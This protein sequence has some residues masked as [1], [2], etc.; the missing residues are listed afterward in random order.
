MSAW[1]WYLETAF[2]REWNSS[3]HVVI[4]CVLNVPSIQ[5]HARTHSVL[6]ASPLPRF[7]TQFH[8]APGIVTVPNDKWH[9][10]NEW[11]NEWAC[12]HVI[13]FEKKTIDQCKEWEEEGMERKYGKNPR[14]GTRTQTKDTHE[15]QWNGNDSEC[16]T[17]LYVFSWVV[18]Y[19]SC[20]SLQRA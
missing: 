12:E 9:A 3:K 20:W 6:C 8:I 7:R 5:S 10:M 13:I 1:N 19:Y 16:Q 14:M 4:N 2:L 11:A 18:H 17:I 15:H